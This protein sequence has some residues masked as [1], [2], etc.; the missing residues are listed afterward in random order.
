M[1]VHIGLATHYCASNCH[2]L[3]VVLSRGDGACVRD[4]SSKKYLELRMN[5]V[6]DEIDRRRLAT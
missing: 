5:A 4:E 6:I 1:S 2:P 3:P